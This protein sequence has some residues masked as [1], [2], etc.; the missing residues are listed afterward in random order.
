MKSKKDH[1][2]FEKIPRNYLSGKREQRRLFDAIATKLGIK[3]FSGWYEADLK[4]LQK[5]G[6][7]L[8]RRHGS[9]S[10]VLIRILLRVYPEHKW[11]VWRFDCGFRSYWSDPNNRLLYFESLARQLGFRSLDDWYRVKLSDIEEQKGSSRV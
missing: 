8:S 1:L 7:I 10:A 2:A 9:S 4:D 3:H 5:H 6:V 11:E